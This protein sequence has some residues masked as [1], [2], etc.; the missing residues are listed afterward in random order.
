MRHFGEEG[1]ADLMLVLITGGTRSG[2]S[3][4]AVALAQTM[5][6]PVFFLATAQPVDEEM[7]ERIRRHRQVRPPAWVTIE[8]PLYLAK[9]LAAHAS[10]G[11]VVVLDCVAV[12]LGN[13]LHRHLGGAGPRDHHQAEALRQRALAEAD[14][15]CRLPDTMGLRLI[16]VTSEVGMGLVPETALGR[17]YRDLLG[18]V[19]QMLARRADRVVWMVAGIPVTIKG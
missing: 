11:S 1:L 19:N 6:G 10:R 5:P 18:E 9:A 3:S 13:L 8:E 15:L 7:A 14:A 16:V 2:R 17:L 4:Q 12:W